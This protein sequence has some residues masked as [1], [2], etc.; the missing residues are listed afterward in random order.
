MLSYLSVGAAAAVF[1]LAIGAGFYAGARH[2]QQ[3]SGI[4]RN[5]ERPDWAQESV[6]PFEAI[7]GRSTPPEP[8]D[9]SDD[10]DTEDN[11]ST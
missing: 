9:E 8:S 3:M 5:E 11:D 1:C 4:V 2:V 6:D 10:D 7:V